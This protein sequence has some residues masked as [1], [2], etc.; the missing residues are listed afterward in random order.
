A[1]FASSSALDAGTLGPRSPPCAAIVALPPQV[2]AP[3]SIRR[4]KPRNLGAGH[5]APAC[6]LP[7]G[8]IRRMAGIGALLLQGHRYSCPRREL[9][10]TRPTAARR[11]ILA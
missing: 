10:R 6:R 7:G 4:M 11:S 5:P 3:R 9:E 8:R 2:G 1:I